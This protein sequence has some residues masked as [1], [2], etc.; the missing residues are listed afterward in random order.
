[1]EC[2]GDKC[3][4]YSLES[5]RANCS[6]EIYFLSHECRL[7]LKSSGY[8]KHLYDLSKCPDGGYQPKNNNVLIL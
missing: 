7:H 8:I 4:H 5:R 2:Q 3:I 1:M 6:G